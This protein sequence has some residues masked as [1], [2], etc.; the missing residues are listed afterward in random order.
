M[1]DQKL[2]DLNSATLGVRMPEVRLA[3][4]SVVQTGTVGALLVTIRAY[5]Q[6]HEEGDEA[7]M[8]E[9]RESMRAP[10]PLLDRLGFFELFTPE[11]WIDDDGKNEGRRVVGEL[12]LEYKKAQKDSQPSP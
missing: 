11:E 2:A 5:N 9:L 3:D 10:L 6:A 12:C 8:E 4:G 7:T 1:A